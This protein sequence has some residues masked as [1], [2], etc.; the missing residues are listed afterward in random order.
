MGTAEELLLGRYR[1][2]DLADIFSFLSAEEMAEVLAYLEFRDWQAEEVVMESGEP[3]DFMGFLVEGKLS[4]KMPG[5]FPGKFILVA[6]LERGSLVG[7]IAVVA[8][9]RR[10]ATVFATEKSCLLILTR[11]K[12]EMMAA[13]SPALGLKFFRRIIHVVGHR[14]GKASDRLS[15]LL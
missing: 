10:Q 12:M 15:R 8:G 5:I 9:G 13:H 6:V 1:P 3:G 2:E 14:L 11:E 4:V 7:E